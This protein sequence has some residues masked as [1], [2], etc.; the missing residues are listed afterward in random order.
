MLKVEEIKSL[1][2]ALHESSINELE[3]EQDNVKLSLK[4]QVAVQIAEQPLQVATQPA[5]KSVP[6]HDTRVVEETNVETETVVETKEENKNLITVT[7]P[8]VGTFYSA[9]SPDADPYVQQ[10]DAVDEDTVVCIVEAM[11][12]MNPI[13]SETK[14]KIVE[15]VAENG[16][17]VEY[18]QPL[19]VVE[20]Q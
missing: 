13:V 11:K 16:E 9:P 10:G 7:S 15:I 2:D 5:A 8:M 19:M 1:I 12:L 17:L 14:G 3:L 4:K 18:G 6:T 20:R